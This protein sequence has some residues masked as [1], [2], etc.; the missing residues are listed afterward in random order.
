MFQLINDII[1]QFRGSFKRQKTWQWFVCII[2]GF[3][4]RGDHR[5]VTS[6]ISAL[7]LKPQLYHTLLHFFRSK[8]YKVSELYKKWVEIV[9]KHAILLEVRGRM[10]LIGDHIKIAK[11]GR[12]M[13]CVQKH[14][15]SSE[16]CGKAE[17]IEGHIFGQISAV[18]TNGVESRA[19]PLMSEL[20]ES[21]AKTGGDTLITQTVKLA[22]EVTK[23]A[24][25]PAT[26]VLDAYF[27]SG[28]TFEAAD[29]ITDE[30][31]NRMLEIV[32]RAKKDTVAYRDPVQSV[33]GKAGRPRKYGEKVKL[34]DLFK[35]KTVNFASAK[36]L[37]YGKWKEV[38]YLC[39]DLYWKPAERKIRFILAKTG[40]SE[41]VIMSSD[42][43]L[44]SREVITLYASRFKI[45]T[46]FDDQKNDMGGFAYHFW[47][48]ALP[49]RK[50]NQDTVVPADP[51]KQEKINKT[52][53]AIAAWVCLGIIAT[54]ILTIIGFAYNRDIWKH[55]PG[56]IKTVSSRIPSVAATK[57]TFAQLWGDISHT[58]GS[59][60][61]FDFIP[62]LQRLVEFCQRDA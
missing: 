4:V 7:R 5:G 34:Y 58:L 62:K 12:R 50:R 54:G 46:G 33:K 52:K 27:C 53:Q 26:L 16:N 25:K 3:M 30:E 49:K 61:A 45:E 38:Q 17:Y 41:I 59:F 28:K 57:L 56:Y 14:H 24:N 11:E 10:V 13:P 19:I 48:D 31:D 23:S 9:I 36:M 2:L 22:G 18:I 40:A 55:Y 42:R 37:L 21:A 35:D 60:R 51:K 39:R 15:Q 6:T 44:T 1:A 8:A 47:T 43:R 29:T 20:Q 32:T